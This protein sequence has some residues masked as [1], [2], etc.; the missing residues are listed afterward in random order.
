M[1]Q[2]IPTQPAA[3]PQFNYAGLQPMGDYLPTLKLEEG[4]SAMVSFLD[5]IP[6][7]QNPPFVYCKVHWNSEMGENGRLFQCFGGSC[8]E[9]ITWQKGWGGE[10]GKFDVNKARTRYFIPVVHYDQDPQNPAAMAAVIK[11]IDMTYTA[12]NA[13]ITTIQNSTEGLP[14]FKRDVVIT[15]RK[16][17]GATD[18]LYTKKESEA[19]WRVNP[20][21]K[22]QVETQLPNVAQRLLNAMPKIM[23][24]AEFQEL[25]PELDRKVQAAMN[26]HSAVNQPGAQAGFGAFPGQVAAP[27]PGVPSVPQAPGMNAV[28]QQP[29]GIPNGN[30]QGV[31]VPGV[32]Q[33]PVF[34]QPVVNIPV[35]P[36]EAQPATAIAAATPTAEVTSTTTVGQAETP[37]VEIPS[38]SLEFDPSALL[39]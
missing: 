21:F 32:P 30:V 26:S 14:F 11:Y 29:A 37:A 13:L 4:K 12:Y 5:E 6:G 38:V 36:I 22:E 27:V 20:V 24:E 3:V 16:V 31:P 33:A 25:K 28:Y 19:Q 35:Q 18:Y 39:K 8:C 34:E 2:Q 23:T 15:V 1:A 7:M 9:Q 10:P 17:N